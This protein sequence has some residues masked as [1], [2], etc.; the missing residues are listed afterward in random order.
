MLCEFCIV[1]GY[2]YLDTLETLFTEY[3]PEQLA[4]LFR[5]N[6]VDQIYDFYGNKREDTEN[7]R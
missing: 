3:S 7:T 2:E 1:T 6:E 5:K 4:L